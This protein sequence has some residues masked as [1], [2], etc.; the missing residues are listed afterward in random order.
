MNAPERVS[1]LAAAWVQA[2]AEIEGAVKNS[3]NPH[4][5]SKFADLP[6]VIAAIKPHLTRH[7]LA[8]IQPLHPHDKGITVETV[9]MH[10]SGETL[11][12]GSLFVPAVKNDPQGFGSA[13]TYARRFA[14]QTAFG[15]P[16]FDDDGE[17]AREAQERQ[18]HPLL[19]TLRQAAMEGPTALRDAFNEHKDDP[20][21]ADIWK[22]H[23]AA[24]KSAAEQAGEVQ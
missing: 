23:S 2:F 19:I 17:A 12:L 11:S 21:L 8:F 4:Y 3:S 24:L 7:G 6:S 22:R 20:A 10:E 14:L 1:T 9:L 5:K 16:A 18:P 13:C 15:L